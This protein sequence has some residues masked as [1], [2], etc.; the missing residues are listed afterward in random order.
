MKSI[1][2]TFCLFISILGFSQ[3]QGRISTPTI[4][5]KIPLGEN[6]TLG[7]TS[8]Q[9]MEVLE[10]SRCPEGATCIWEGQCKVKI[11][12]TDKGDTPS[13]MEILFNSKY[14]IKEVTTK[15]GSSV[16]FH[17]LTPYPNVEDE[18]KRAYALLVSEN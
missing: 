14:K 5:V 13:E 8:I 15:Q 2:F 7:D 1:V 3:E 18:G 9:F 17:Q 12:I 6:V 16:K 10:D 11:L 4:A